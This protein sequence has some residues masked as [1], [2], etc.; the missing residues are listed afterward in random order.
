MNLTVEKNPLISVYRA[1]DTSDYR[2]LGKWLDSPAHNSREDVRLLH[3]YLTR[4]KDRLNKTSALSKVRI[5]KHLFPA[6]SFDDA[7]LRQTF[8]WALKATEVFL[9]F[10][11]WQSD[12]LAS[13][14]ALIDELRKRNVASV[15]IKSLN[16]AERIHREI[17]VRNEK[18]YR[19]QYALELARDEIRSYYKL[20]EA[21]RFQEIADT[22]DHTYF[23]EKLKASGNMLFHQRVYQTEFNLKMIDEVIA[24]VEKLDLTAFP[25]LAIHYYGY[26]GLTE[27]DTSGEVIALLRAAVSDHGS[28]LDRTD[29]RYVILMA[30]NLCIANMTHGLETYVRESFEWYKLG[31]S[32]EVIATNGLLTRATYLNV[33]NIAL[34]LE[35]FEWVRKF[36]DEQSYQLEEEDRENTERFAR[37]RVAY[38]ESD[39][40]DSMQ[41][42]VQVDFKHPVYN[43]LAK[44]QLLKIYYELDEY[45]AMESQLDSMTT[46]IRRKEIAQVRKDNFSNIVRYVRQLSRVSPG[47]REKLAQLKERVTA[48]TPLTEKKW[49]LEQISRR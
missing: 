18:Y 21:P 35:E 30:I 33:V 13:Q 14:L 26:R 36:I 45:D 28:L 1:M 31:F 5:W 11:N 15:A 42:L 20:M 47:D 17:P 37:A 24:E 29:L 8:H 34:K 43:L 2:R 40:D 22:L 44:T 6:E 27:D 4:G 12:P 7:R 48:A 46:Y 32:R 38:E 39:Y 9:A 25:V 16:K 19:D 3:A 10:E 41:K 23:I 49:L